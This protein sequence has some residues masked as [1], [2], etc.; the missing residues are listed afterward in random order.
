M[1]NTASALLIISIILFS[2]EKVI[3]I[4]PPTYLGKVSIQSM[5]EPD[6]L[7][8][9]YFNR[10]VPYFGKDVSLGSLVIRNAVVKITSSAGTDILHFDSVFSKTYCQYD[11]YYKGNVAIQLNQTYILAV[12]S[13]ADTYTA[14]ASTTLSR[15]TIDSTSY[16][17]HFSDLYGDHEGVIVYFRDLPSQV[18]FYRYEMVRY[19]DTSTQQAGPKLPASTCLDHTRKDS[20]LVHELGRSVYSDLGQAGQQI[21]IVIEPA[22]THQQGTRGTIYIQTID[23]NAFDFFDQLDK[24]KLA[25]FNPFVEPVFLRDGQFGSKVIGYFSAMVKSNPVAYIFPE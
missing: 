4:K 20:T 24:Q 16:T 11:Y 8:V 25:Q 12:I 21:K 10:T 22:Y 23:K 5:L 15:A 2:C 7:P 18:N 6:S 13:G 19:V 1:K 14:T 9:V 3:T 17:A